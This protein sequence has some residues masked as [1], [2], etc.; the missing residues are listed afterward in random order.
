MVNNCLGAWILLYHESAALFSAH[1]YYAGV[2]ELFFKLVHQVFGRLFQQCVV[3][4]SYN[5]VIRRVYLR[6]KLLKLRI[7]AAAHAVARDG[8]LMHLATDYNS[9]PVLFAP[10]IW[11]IFNSKKRSAYSL[12]VAVNVV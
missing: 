9:R 2:F 10:R 5:N 3:K 1:V 11:C 4:D 12:A 8:G 7:N 6:L